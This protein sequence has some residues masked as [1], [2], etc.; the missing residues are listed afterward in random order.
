MKLKTFRGGIHPDGHKDIS[1][2]QP[3]SSYLPNGDLIFP[4]NQHIGKPAFKTLCGTVGAGD[5]KGTGKFE[6][7]KTDRK[8]SGSDGRHFF[9]RHFDLRRRHEYQFNL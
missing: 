9:D 8:L 4:V 3:V 7:K 1:K 2:G 6:C 5:R